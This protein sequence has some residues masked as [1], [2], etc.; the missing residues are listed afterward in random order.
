[1]KTY[2]NNKRLREPNAG[3]FSLNKESTKTK[4]H[5]FS[6]T[7]LCHVPLMRALLCIQDILNKLVSNA[8]NLQERDH[9]ANI[10]SCLISVLRYTLKKTIKANILRYD[11][12]C[13]LIVQIEPR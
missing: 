10:I 6:R 9:F 2:A 3:F 11:F 12:I 8:G 7:V 4:S 1:M 13:T 5:L